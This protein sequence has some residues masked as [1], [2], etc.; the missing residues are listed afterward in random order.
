MIS[1]LKFEYQPLAEIMLDK[2][3]KFVWISTSTTFIDPAMGGGQFLSAVQKRLKE[4]GHS[5][6]NIASRIFGYE[7][8]ILRVNFAVNKHKLMGTFDHINALEKTF[9]QKFTVVVANPPFESEN[10]INE[11]R[12]QPQNHSLWPQ[13]VNKAFEELVETNGYI[14]FTTPDSWMSPTNKVYKMFKEYNLLWA[15][16]DCKEY[17][18]NVGTSSTAWVARKS[19]TSV[20]TDFG[21]VKVNLEDFPYLPRFLEKSITIHKKVLNFKSSKLNVLGDNT[22]H[23]SKDVVS[24]TQDAVFK[25]PLQHT[26]AQMRYGS[27]KSKYQDNFK[28]MWT[29]SGN[30][31]PKIDLGV[32]GFTEPNQAI[33]VETEEQANAVYSVMNSKLYHYIVTTAKWSG[34]LNGLVFKLLPDLGC[35]KVWTDQEIYKNFNLSKHEIDTIEEYFKPK[36]S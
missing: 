8:N 6:E 16:T 25:Y 24:K 14:C 32:L 5:D 34:F 36:N 2:L 7:N 19:K 20:E 35:N 9:D 27:I 22:C 31:V 1:R 11:D 13:Y 15:K 4:A 21:S 10:K 29:T 12:K 30:Y 3:P 17:F 33:V 28:V 23:G 26:N 18:P